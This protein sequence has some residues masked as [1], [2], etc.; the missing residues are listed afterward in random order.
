[1]KYGDVGIESLGDVPIIDV[2]HSMGGLVFKKAYIQGSLNKEYQ[3]ITRS[4]KAALFLATPHRGTD[5]AKTLNR[6]LSSSIFGHSPKDYIAE[7]TK[8]STTIDELNESFRHH[9]HKLKIFSFYE[10]LTTPV[11]PRNI[12]VLEKTSSLLGYPNET[13]QALNA[14]HHYVCK[15]THREDPN[16]VSVRG[17]VRSVIKGTA[18]SSPLNTAVQN[19]YDVRSLQEYLAVDDST[20]DDAA[21]LRALRK[22]GTCEELLHHK[23]FTEW[24]TSARSCILWISAPPGNGKSI[25][26]SAV[27]DYF[28]E[29]RSTCCYYF[30]K[31][32]DKM[33][34]SL[35]R[36][37][38]SLAL[39]LALQI[40]DV[41][42]VLFEHMKVGT[43]IREA[44]GLTAWRI[45]FQQMLSTLHMPSD[46][47]WII[48]GLDESESSKAFIDAVSAT[49]S[50]KSPIRILIFSRPLPLINQAIQR[51]SKYIDIR[52]HRLLQNLKDIRL[53]VEELDYLVSD[54]AFKKSTISQISG[55]SNGN[56]L[57][58]SLVVKQVL[59]CH[60]SED[61]KN[62]LDT[63][64][65]GMRQLYVRMAE[66]VSNLEF[67][68][69]I[70]LAR[71][72]LGWATHSKRPLS[73][74]ELKDAYPSELGTVMDLR[75]TS[76]QLG[77][78]FISIDA[79][80]QLVLVHH[81][82][83]EFLRSSR[84]LPFSLD[85]AVVNEDHML[86][87]LALLCS[88]GLRTK[89][90]QKR[91]PDFLNYAAMS[92]AFHLDYVS[93]SSDKVLDALV[94][95]FK[96]ASSIS[97]VHYLASKN[98]MLD[99]VKAAKSLTKFVQKRRKFDLEKISSASS[100]F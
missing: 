94:R 30:F 37:F 23:D 16:Y 3:S 1:M 33:R 35:S 88:R 58:A 71:L 45:L 73:V 62:V 9:S 13:T 6:I 21:A 29:R 28:L 69:D 63:T 22:D 38:R 11:G 55:R 78:Q 85:P 4:I 24:S 46:I 51:A 72:L 76:S 48:D 14:N 47:Y 68:E 27:L 77:G 97:W 41:R 84:E 32:S 89:I 20:A 60:R 44:D 79:N 56:F 49:A 92:W 93:S 61:V 36:C 91:Y 99:I 74:D 54:D 80:G 42:E 66:T 26:A 34:K 53:I 2:A 83:K 31:Y 18:P 59:K 7:L 15:F 64:P 95:L 70:A 19:E 5:L 52:L 25:Q 40:S 100:S 90:N 10:T 17:A 86:K 98:S 39:Q 87:C 50:F 57:W 81:T 8:N 12:M 43:P 82:A 75:N 67:S 65:N 96:S